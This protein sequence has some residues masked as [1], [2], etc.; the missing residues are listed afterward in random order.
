MNLDAITSVFSSVPTDWMILGVLSIFVAFDILRSGARR[1]CTAALALPIALLLFVTTE[2]VVFLSDVISQFS[3]PI[4]QAVLV[5]ILFAAAYV[6]VN[7][8]SLSWGGET[9]QTIQA[10][11]GGVAVTAIFATLWLATPAL[12]SVWQFGPSVQEIFG[13]SYRFFWLFG[14]Y[15][16]LA[17]VRNS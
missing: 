3:T 11:L 9:G 16:A 12:D 10:A 2:N 15:A 7:R 8:I 6:V 1:A 17:F 13:E 4:L 5:G 14:A